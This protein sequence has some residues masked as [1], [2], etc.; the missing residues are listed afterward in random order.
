MDQ[1]KDKRSQN[2]PGERNAAPQRSVLIVDDDPLIREQIEKELRRSYFVPLAAEDGKGALATLAREKIDIVLLDIKLP[3]MD[4][5]ELLDVIKKEKSD[6]EVI[7]LTGYG[8]EE[9]AI[10]AIRKGAIDY[11]EKPFHFEEFSAALGRA[12]ERL[13]ESQGLGFQNTILVIDDEEEVMVRLKRFLEKE[14][15]L[16]FGTT[17]PEEG[18]RIIEQNKIDVVIT[19]VKMKE[20]DG[21]ELL[22]RAKALY[23]DIEGIVVTGFK[24]ND[25]AVKALRTGASDYLTKPINLE[26]LLVSVER[27]IE[28]INLY[29]TRFYRA[30]ELRISQE[31]TTK[32]NEE[33]ERRIEE[34]SR[35]LNKTQ[36][37]LAQ[38]SKLATLGE[39]AA[40]LAHEINQPLAG[41][42]FV[43]TS[44]KKLME[45]QKLT[46]QEI[47]S[48]IKD[49]EMSVKRMS[50]I[51]KHIRTFARQ[52]TLVFTEVDVADTIQMAMSL[53]GEQLRLHEVEAL[54][55]IEPDV[56]KI[57]GEPFQLEQVWINLI[58]NA[59]DAMDGKQKKIAEGKLSVENYKRRL[60][61]SISHQKESNM[62]LVAFSDNGLGMSEEQKKKAFEPFFT[63]KEVGKGTGLGLSISYGIIDAHHG[64]IDI[65]TVDGEGTTMKV[66]LPVEPAV[67]K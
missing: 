30:R 49:I 23:Q 9:I 46:P 62:V 37:Q 32:M 19:D 24:D 57:K 16:V 31:I 48:G 64:K 21:I 2:A 65:E 14:G 38:T 6:C 39:M 52:E 1:E 10:Q 15:F 25:L 26:E 66:Y 35:E 20:M 53:L 5:I 29:R 12:Q 61:I 27:G 60:T 7:V 3:D 4:G 41:I 47:E 50:Q 17:N 18:L 55:Q 33:L 22:R 63:T 43:A 56:P 59:R 28:R 42:S 67:D 40:G 11:I 45:R 58:S 34:R 13:S 51:I 8:S 44:F 54:Q 36:A